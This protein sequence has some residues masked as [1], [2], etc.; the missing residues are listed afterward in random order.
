MC[1]LRLGETKLTPLTFLLHIHIK[2]TSNILY[3]YYFTDGEKSD[4]RG[5]ER[6]WRRGDRGEKG[7]INIPIPSS[8]N[9]LNVQVRAG[10]W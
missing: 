7:R 1:W 10:E 2:T 5:L 4:D 8:R 6:R 9:V 3:Y